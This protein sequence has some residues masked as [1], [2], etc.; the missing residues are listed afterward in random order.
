MNGIIDVGLYRTQVMIHF[1]ELTELEQIL[2][3]Y[4]GKDET[5][6]VLTKFNGNESGKTLEL[7]GGQIIIYLPTKPKDAD[8]FALLTHELFHATHFILEKVGITFSCDSDEAFAYLLDY[9]VERT[10]ST[11]SLSLQPMCEDCSS[12]ALQG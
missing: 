2:K 3:S 9:L 6:E 12:L 8:S 5:D 4:L 10:I 7:S 11:F 1:G